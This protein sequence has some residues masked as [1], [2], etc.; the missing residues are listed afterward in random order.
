MQIHKKIDG[1]LFAESLRAGAANLKRHM[2]EINDLNVFP[3]PDGDT[4]SNML[5]TIMGGVEGLDYNESSIS[6]ASRRAADG[7]LLSARG[8]SGV[9]LSQ[10]FDGIA[11]GLDGIDCADTLLLS[12]ALSNGVKQAYSA[13]IEPVEGTILTVARCAAEYAERSASTSIESQCRDYIAEAKR[14]LDKTPDMLPVLKRAGVVDSGGAGLICIAEGVK[15]ALCGESDFSQEELA[16]ANQITSDIDINRFTEDSILEYGYCTELLLRLQNSK[17][18]P[19]KFDVSTISEYLKTVGDSVVAFKT[20]SIVKIHVHTMTPDKVLCFCRQFGE[21]LT[22]KIENMSL[23]H[24]SIENDDVSGDNNDISLRKKIGIT[25]VCS[26]EGIAQMF[27]ERGADIIIDGGQSMNPSAEDFL[28][29]FEKINAESIIVLPNNSNVILSA[30]QAADMY[31]NANIYVLES[32]TIGDGYAALSMLNPD[33]E[34]METLMNDL[35]DAMCGVVTAEIAE[36]VR[37]AQVQGVQVHKGDYIG[38]VGKDYLAS[39]SSRL[40][41]ACKTVDVLNLKNYDICIIVMGKNTALSE[42]RELEKHI[43]SSCSGIEL[44]AVDGNQD[45]YDY[46]IILQ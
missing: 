16:I 9:I 7:M 30:K 36:C 29:A 35:R 42:E 3:I 28:K 20:G 2:Q 37:D 6:K 45:I 8:N 41:T 39:D 44:F 10:L 33:E 19:Q 31:K 34:N 24:N 46:I 1:I 17:T 11:K 43:Q 12:K 26:G 21:F 27:R 14:T 38:I 13:V 22:V 18:N 5:L 40:V 23:Q 25:A 4:G 15:M 32:K